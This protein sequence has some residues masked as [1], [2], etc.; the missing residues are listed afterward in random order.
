M[1]NEPREEERCSGRD[2]EIWRDKGGDQRENNKEVKSGRKGEK[3]SREGGEKAR[4]VYKCR[5]QR[6]SKSSSNFRACM[7]HQCSTC[8]V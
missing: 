4:A 8:K 7:L 5:K 6:A 1:S 2:V 3:R